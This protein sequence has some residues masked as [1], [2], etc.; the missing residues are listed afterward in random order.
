MP[1]QNDNHTHHFKMTIL[2]SFRNDFADKS[3]K[4]SAINLY[5]FRKE[6][7]TP[8]SEMRGQSRNEH[9]SERSPII[10]HIE[11]KDPASFRK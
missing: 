5:S 10:Y 7:H 1:F 11:K 4:K 9:H 2:L 8:H 3:A 6:G